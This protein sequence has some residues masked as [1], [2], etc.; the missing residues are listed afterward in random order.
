MLYPNQLSCWNI[1][2]YLL[3]KGLSEAKQ[4]TLRNFIILVDQLLD[5]LNLKLPSSLGGD[6]SIRKNKTEPS[7]L[8][9]IYSSVDLARAI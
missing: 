9:S 6:F 8:I 2:N 1:F 4:V 3:Y 7:A 5:R